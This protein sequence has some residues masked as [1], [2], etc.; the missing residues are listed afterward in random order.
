M[1]AYPPT[2]Q[3]DLCVFCC[4]CIFVCACV[5]FP[6]LQLLCFYHSLSLAATR[7]HCFVPFHSFSVLPLSLYLIARSISSRLF[8]FSQTPMATSLLHVRHSLVCSFLP[9]SVS[10]FF[11]LSFSRSLKFAL[12]VRSFSIEALSLSLFRE[13]DTTATHRAEEGRQRQSETTK[14]IFFFHIYFESRLSVLCQRACMPMSLRHT[15][16]P[17]RRR[18][19]DPAA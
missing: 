1:Q 13:E 5:D 15:T 19:M 14:L 2:R 12:P 4:S 17:R 18:C 7:P 3:S 11:W 8:P 9:T 16:F 10:F 6:P